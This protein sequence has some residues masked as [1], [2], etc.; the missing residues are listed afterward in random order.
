M[1]FDFNTGVVTVYR[2]NEEITE[3]YTVKHTGHHFG[4]DR[5]LTRNFVDL[6]AGTAASMAPLS[7]GILS[8]DMCLAAKRSARNH[9]FQKVNL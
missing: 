7:E 4:G 9:S 6:M 3:T 2:H 8:A 1:E 5:I